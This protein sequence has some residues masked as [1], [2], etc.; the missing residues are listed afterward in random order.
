M[1]STNTKN[2]KVVLNHFYKLRHDEKRAIIHSSQ[3]IS[4]IEVNQSWVSKV[5]PIYAMILSFLSKPIT[6]RKLYH[7]ISYFLETSEENAQKIITPFINQP[8]PFY[9]EYD[10]TLNY[11]PKNIV[12][13]SSESYA[14]TVSYTPEQFKYKEVDIKQDRFFR[15]PL[16]AVFMINNVCA[17]DCAYCYADKT[18]RSRN[19]P[20]EKLKNIIKNASELKLATFSV[21]G[22]EFFLYKR[23][24]ELFEILTKYGYKQG[25]V[26]TK[27]PIKKDQILIIKQ[28]NT[29]I[30]ISLDSIEDNILSKILNVQQGYADKI[31]TSISLMEKYDVPFQI[32][33]VLTSYNACISNLSAIYEFIKDF[34]NIKR[35]EIRLAFRSLYSR[36]NFDEIKINAEDISMLDNWILNVKKEGKINIAWDITGIDRYFKST[37]G[38]KGFIGSKCSANYSNI[39]ILPDGQVSICEQLYWN[40]QYIIGNLSKQTIEEVWNSK[41]AHELAFPKKDNFREQSACRNCE[42]FDKCHS[43]INKCIVD[44]LKGYGPENSDYPDPRCIKAPL[45]IHELRY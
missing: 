19:L 33:T 14:E 29:T 20:F 43:F 25:V 21:T 2:I 30:Q 31:K 16:T 35:W 17:T 6:L 34:K 24:K 27:V 7:E 44:V 9:L 10:S 26:S 22:G 28:Y 41:R 36:E 1:N 45:F 23:W 32:A 12:I 11:F 37:T 18:F 5:H 13:S 8:Q 39:F 4:K 42:I 38:S 15:A 40:P 3:A